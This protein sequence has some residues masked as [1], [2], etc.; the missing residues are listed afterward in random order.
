[1]LLAQL[2][3]LHFLMYQ[4]LAVRGNCNEGQLLK[5]RSSDIPQ[6]KGWLNDRKYQSPEIVNEQIEL[7]FKNVL[8]S[9]LTNIKEQPFYGLIADET[10]DISGKE[11][12]AVCLRWVTDS[13]EIHEDLIGLAYVE[14]TEDRVSVSIILTS[15][16]ASDC[17]IQTPRTERSATRAGL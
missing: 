9:L 4:G 10:R 15:N 8:R 13:Y 7:M 11:Q 1:M 12:L 5:L 6:L 16:N 17:G 14:T 3:S 2:Q